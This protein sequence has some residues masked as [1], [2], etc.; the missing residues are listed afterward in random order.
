[1]SN[2]KKDVPEAHGK[3]KRD[4][5]ERELARLHVE[6]VKLQQWAVHK[7]EERANYKQVDYPFRIIPEVF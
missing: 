5:Y 4:D 3:V 2:E 1:M 7:R 6:L